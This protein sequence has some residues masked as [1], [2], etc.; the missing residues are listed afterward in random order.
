MRK[1]IFQDLK[2]IDYKKAWDYQEEIFNKVLTNKATAVSGCCNSEETDAGYILFCEHPHV[3]TLGKSGVENNLLIDPGFLG[4]IGATYYKINRGGDI[5]YHGP[6][7]LVG[8]PILNLELLG[9]Q[10]K[11]YIYLLEEAI[12]KTLS[13]F[14]ISSSR[15]KNA[16]GVWLDAEESGKSRKI[17]AIGVRASRYIT[18]HGFAFNINTDISYFGYINPCGMA[19]KGVTSLQKE[20][21]EA[22]DT[23]KVKEE[24]KGH[25]SELFGLRLEEAKTA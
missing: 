3:F 22:Q 18:M 11:Q 4:K 20:L 2:K 14:G 19:D 24:V 23:E 17:C 8:Y 5:T 13:G 16:T 1:A 15:M 7:Q 9:L 12:I 10:V 6:G 25:L 21:G